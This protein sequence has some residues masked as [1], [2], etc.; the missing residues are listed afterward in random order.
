[1]K[2]KTTMICWAAAV[3]VILML[4]SLCVG[5]G[6]KNTASEEEGTQPTRTEQQ[7][8][9]REGIY[10]QKDEV[11]AYL[12]AY[13]RLPRNYITKKEAGRLGWQGGALEPYAPGMCIGGDYFGNYE[14]VLPDDEYHECDIDTKRKKSR[15]VKRLVY[16]D[17]EIYYTEDHYQTFELLY[18]EN[19]KL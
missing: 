10:D 4:A 2:K 11:A 8:P 7:A 18:D 1:M 13:E 6:G 17:D 19:G 16:S 15:G 14:G 3:A 5:C 9:D 12:Y